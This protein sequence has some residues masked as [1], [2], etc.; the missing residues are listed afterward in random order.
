[1]NTSPEY[2]QL[3]RYVGQWHG[4]Q[5]MADLL[6]WLPRGVMGGLLAGV[7]VAAVA[8]WRPLFTNAEVGYI[9]LGCA[10]V[11]LLVGAVLGLLQ[12]Q[13][14]ERTHW[15]DTQFGLYNRLTAAVQLQQGTI[16]TT[17]ALARLQLQDALVHAQQVN[18]AEGIP[19]RLDG[20]DWGVMLAAVL[21]LAAAVLLP[22]PQVDA[23]LDQRIIQ[24]EIAN[25]I[26]AIEKI[27][28]AIAANPDLTEEQKEELLQPLQDAR[29]Q[30]EAGNLSREEALATLSQA[31]AELR[32]L[33]AENDNAAL[34]EQLGRAAAPLAE[35]EAGQ[36]TGEALQNGQLG[37]ASQ[38]LSELAESLPGL[39]A[40][41]QGQLAEALAETAAGLQGTDDQ[42]AQQLN[43]AAEALQNGDTAS[44][45]QA[46]QE[47]SATLGE[48]AQQQAAN[49][50]AS[51]AAESLSE[52]QQQMAQAGQQGQEGQQSQQGQGEGQQGAEQGE[53]QQQGQGQGQGEGQQQGQGQG[54]QQGQGQLGQAGTGGASEG[55][56]SAESVFAPEFID[57]SGYEGVEIE[58]P[59]ECVANP[60]LCGEL[61]N[62]SPTD[63]GDEQS[64]VPYSQVYGQYREEAYEALNNDY[65][66]LGLKGYIRDYFTSLEPN[67]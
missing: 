46:L 11:G 22:N 54:N 59:A 33:A 47:A 51:Q 43:E 53:G 66:P 64:L 9:A 42:L 61:L 63:F 10:A 7:V 6:L 3:L 29:E 49:Q 40:E 19:L 48:Q 12:R 17:P 36:Q 18:A 28:E 60:T 24:Q 65:I 35:N 23:L 56:G 55:G 57:L 52:G 45:Q 8:R 37:E 38:S 39:T 21:L 32:D 50:A 41:Q 4:R 26:E 30:L 15:A 20:R 34:R 58:L 67:R 27:E 2:N 1:M 5:Q 14:G 62:V 16:T 25:Q 44:A 13:K 31:Q